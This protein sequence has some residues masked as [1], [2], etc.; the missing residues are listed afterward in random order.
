[1][2]QHVASGRQEKKP[3]DAPA[4]PAHLWMIDATLFRET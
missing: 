4:L 3:T 2:R 1:M